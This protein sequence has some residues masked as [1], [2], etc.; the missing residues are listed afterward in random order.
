MLQ[1]GG[2]WARIQG[3]SR[4][5]AVLEI[6]LKAGVV[7]KEKPECITEEDKGFGCVVCQYA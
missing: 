7:A 5:D 6:V 2:I 4:E 1:A 3:N